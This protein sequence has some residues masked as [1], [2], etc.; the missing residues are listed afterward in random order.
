MRGGA[1][2]TTP[3]A[4]RSANRAGL[5]PGTRY[6]NLGFRLVRP[7][8]WPPDDHRLGE[9]GLIDRSV[10]AGKRVRLPLGVVELQ[11][12]PPRQGAPVSF[13]MVAPFRTKSPVADGAIL[14]DEYGE[15]LAIDFTDDDNPGRIYRGKKPVNNP[16]DLSAELFM[17]YTRDGLWIAVR[18][19]DDKLVLA[20]TRWIPD[21]DEVELFID[22][23]RR[24]NDF[25]K[26]TPGNGQA[27]PE[28]FQ[29]GTDSAGR[30]YANGIGAQ[31]Y[32]VKAAPCEGGYVVECGIPLRTIDTADGDEIEHPARVRPYDSTWPSLTTTRLQTVK[33]DME[34]SG[35]KTRQ[36]DPGIK[37]RRRG[38]S[39]CTWPAR[40]STSWSP[41]PR[42]RRS[43]RN[44]RLHL[45]RLR[46]A[47]DRKGHYPRSRRRETRDHLRSEFCTT[48]IAGR[49]PEVPSTALI[50]HSRTRRQGL[51]GETELLDPHA[52]RKKMSACIPRTGFSG[53]APP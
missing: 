43:T 1:W 9:T 47:A 5:T 23:D 51:R 16:K 14:P 35:V 50:Q 26:A 2:K 45:G 52:L 10:P 29:I 11:S 32:T 15:P 13:R 12:G 24:A 20:S 49:P 34:C 46:R 33:S 48:T 19:H 22:G 7:P 40:S 30:T 39:T 28:G 27:R 25:D 38:S 41:V 37:A 36:G 18:V 21:G 44:R 3:R 17:A 42:E 8:D 6:H 4:F 31:N 53:F